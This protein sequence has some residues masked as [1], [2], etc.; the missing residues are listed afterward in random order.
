MGVQNFGPATV[1]DLSVKAQAR[2][3]NNKVASQEGHTACKT[4]TI[5]KGFLYRSAGKPGP[6]CGCHGKT[7]QLQKTK[8]YQRAVAHIIS[9]FAQHSKQVSRCFIYEH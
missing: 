2:P 8:V 7:V 3:R 6:N 9:H 5:C 1:K 4:S